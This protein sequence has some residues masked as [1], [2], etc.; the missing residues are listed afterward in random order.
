MMMF[1]LGEQCQSF[2]TSSDEQYAD[3]N[4]SLKIDRP[5]DGTD[6]HNSSYAFFGS[7]SLWDWGRNE[8]SII[9]EW[10][11]RDSGIGKEKKKMHF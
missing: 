5:S 11:W 6:H 9:G 2:N 3:V 10:A 1:P 8:T 7:F 4:S